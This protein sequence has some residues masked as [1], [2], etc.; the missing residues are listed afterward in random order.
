[1]TNRISRLP[2]WF[3]VVGTGTLLFV[4]AVT[5]HW[6]EVL[7]IDQFVEPLAAFTLDGALAAG[8]VY[9]GYW[10][11]RT[12]LSR[13]WRWTACR[14]SLAG[15]VLFATVTGLTIL[16]RFIEGRV[17][18]E[19]VFPMLVAVEAGLLAG[20]AAGYN[21]ARVQRAAVE[22][23]RVSQR[24]EDVNEELERPTSASSSSR[25]RS[26]TTCRSPCGWSP[27]TSSCWR[28]DTPTSSI[29]TQPSSSASP[30]TAPTGWSR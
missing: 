18:A 11:S 29:R 12:E 19:P 6:N 7:A 16:I 9:A 25:T 5:H 8:V 17:V 22:E 13:E 2:P 30:S 14:Y 4:V 28:T 27:R 10:L 24:L 21:N 26:H 3:P 15:G 1:M 20:L 23:R